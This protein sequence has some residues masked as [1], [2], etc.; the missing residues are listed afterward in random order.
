VVLRI[1][2]V[3]RRTPDLLRGRVSAVNGL[4]IACSNQWGA[5]ESGLTAQ[6]FGAVPS[7]VF[8]GMATIVV[9]GAIWVLSKSLRDWQDA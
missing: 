5:V 9:V 2:L 7:V 1:S 6:W 4:F 3:Q 8:G